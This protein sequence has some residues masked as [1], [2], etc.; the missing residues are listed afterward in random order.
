MKTI[1]IITYSLL[2]IANLFFGLI[3]VRTWELELHY[4][5]LCIGIFMIIMSVPIN[6]DSFKNKKRII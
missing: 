5:N 6:W 3:N 1:A 2:A 4:L